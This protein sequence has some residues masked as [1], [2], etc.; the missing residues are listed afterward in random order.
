MKFDWF[1][2]CGDD[3]FL[4]PQ[5]IRSVAS[6]Y[7]N[8]AVTR[9]KKKLQKNQQ[10]ET[11]TT[12]ITPPPLYL[13]SSIPHAK[14]PNRRYCGGGAGYMLNRQAVLLLNRRIQ[15]GDCPDAVASNEDIRVARCL[16]DAGVRC[17]DTNDLE[18]EVRFHHLDVQYHTSW[19]PKQ[20]ALWLW[21]K[22]QYFHGIR[23][24]QS[25][26]EQISN[27][28]TTFHLDKS[29]VRTVERD[30]GIRR[31]YA[32]LHPEEICGPDFLNQMKEAATC[33]DDDEYYQMIRQKWMEVK[34]PIKTRKRQR[35]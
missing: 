12:T 15:N 22:L 5:N 8:Q 24:N 4:I 32:L 31:Y 30:R 13:G 7:E 26:L 18:G 2:I 1:I 28:T 11:T 6:Y 19:T 17:H 3:T 10:Q 23:G 20:S 14:N 29:K 25:R 9:K 21:P 35:N 16:D 34:K 33:N 27:T